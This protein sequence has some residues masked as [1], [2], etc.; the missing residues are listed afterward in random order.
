MIVMMGAIR[1]GKCTLLAG[2]FFE[3][4]NR[5]VRERT[6]SLHA[7]DSG[8]SEFVLQTARCFMQHTFP[9]PLPVQF[10][11]PLQPLRFHLQRPANGFLAALTQGIEHLE[12]DILNP[13]GE[14]FT[15]P[16]RLMLDNEEAISV[17]RALTASTG[18]LCVVDP[19]RGDGSDPFEFL[20]K[21]FANL[22]MLMNP[23][24][25]GP[26]DVPVAI[27]ISKADAYPAA[28]DDP[29][30][31]LSNAIGDAAMNLI[32]TYCP[33]RKFF[34]LSAIGRGNVEKTPHGYFAP[35]GLPKP[36]GVYEPFEWL[37]ANESRRND[38]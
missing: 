23:R 30:R 29:E 8:T 34:A 36:E 37:L 31:F 4:Q 32:T 38:E 10:G 28:F 13:P 24:D 11:E 7:L 19:D 5:Q 26:F 3:I 22:S 35:K 16:E 9:P 2:L 33:M 25:G 21:N 20:A 1:S 17:R 12:L 27:C 18:V 14:Y 6:W 15:A